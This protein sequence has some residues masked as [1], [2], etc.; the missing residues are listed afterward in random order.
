M[1]LYNLQLGLKI[2]VDY[3]RRNHKRVLIGSEPDHEEDSVLQQGGVAD[4]RNP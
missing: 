3:Q 1:S 4:Q 2:Q